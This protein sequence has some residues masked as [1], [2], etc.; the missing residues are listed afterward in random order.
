MKDWRDSIDYTPMVE[1]LLSPDR[2][3]RAGL[4]K[5][6][7]EWVMWEFD[8]IVKQLEIRLSSKRVKSI[9]TKAEVW[10]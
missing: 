4:P 6:E 1:K 9:N 3:D 10:E 8:Q 7:L 5:S 2:S